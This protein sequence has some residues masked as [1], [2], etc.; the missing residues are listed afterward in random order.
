MIEGDNPNTPAPG[1]PAASG[2]SAPASPLLP[3]PP[4]PPETPE[5]RRA[6]DYWNRVIESVPLI[7]AGVTGARGL[8]PSQSPVTGPE[9]TGTALRAP[10]LDAAARAT[11]HAA[12]VD[13]PA[14]ATSGSLWGALIDSQPAAPVQGLR[15]GRSQRQG[16]GS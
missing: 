15:H 7:A 9:A 16:P 6:Q 2:M 3:P 12:Q 5:Q 1:M 10:G 14:S 4:P 13:T 11:T 8:E